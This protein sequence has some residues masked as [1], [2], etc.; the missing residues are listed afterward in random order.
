MKK[1]RDDFRRKTVEERL[2]HLDRPILAL[3][4]GIA[5]G[6]SSVTRL[7]EARGLVVIDA[8]KLVKKI[9]A[10]DE[11]KEFIR[12]TFPTTWEKGIDFRKLRSLVFSDTTAKNLIE[13]FIYQRLPAVFIEAASFVTGQDFYFYDVPLLFERKLESLVDVTAVVYTPR[14]LQRSRLMQ[15]DALH[16][17]A[18]ERILMQQL[19]IEDKRRRADIVIDN[20]GSEADLAFNVDTCLSRLLEA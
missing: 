15:R 12:T 1:L 4:G 5:T 6:K 17:V 19:D 14:E 10:S 16:A 7:L 11:A 20:S 9:Y 13:G 18:A 2:Y 8:D 3:T